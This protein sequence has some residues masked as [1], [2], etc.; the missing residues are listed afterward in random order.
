MSATITTI[1]RAEFR[2]AA[3]LT[4]LFTQADLLAHTDVPAHTGHAYWEKRLA[5]YTDPAHLPL[6]ALAGDVIVG[7]VLLQSSPNSI[8]RKHCASLSMLAVSLSHR[9]Q[10]V[11]RALV[12]AAIA[13]CD[14]WLNIR[15]I[16]VNIDATTV[17]LQ[18]FYASFGFADEGVCA[19][20]LMCAGYYA[21]S[22]VMSRINDA[23]CP[24]EASPPLVIRRRKKLA[25]I[26]IKVR[27][28][29]AD[30]AEG[31]AH[32]FASHSAANG[33]LQHPYTSPDIWRA[34]LTAGVPNTRQIMLI[35]TV[36]GRNVGNA[37]VHPISDNPRQKHVCGIGIGVIDAYQSRG[38]GRALM[39]ACLDYAGQW[40]NYS[41]VQLTV[42]ADNARAIEL[43]ESLGFVTEGRHRDYSFREGGY[44][45]ALFMGRLSNALKVA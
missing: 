31:Y 20:D 8:R 40:A 1:R 17:A 32:V 35:A 26:N 41:R 23:L 21:S 42:H 7:L 33:T 14:Q 30:D 38:V 19:K 15:R 45:D 28:A 11:G 25:P 9:R 4:S 22:R 39:N 37:G 6:V 44:V 3:S 18:R 13:A 34:R 36:N 29:T 43:Y 2:D 12:N 10:G 27:P 24:A 5:E 16:E